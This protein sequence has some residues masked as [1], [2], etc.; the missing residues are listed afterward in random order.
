MPIKRRSDGKIIEE[1]TDPIRGR[2]RTGS[3]SDAQDQPTDRTDTLRERHADSL[4][5][6][7]RSAAN[8]GMEEPTVPMRTT[9]E[10]NKTRIVRPRQQSEPRVP[11]ADDPMLDPPAGWL[12]IVRGPGKGRALAIGNGMNVLGRG[13]RARVRIDFGDDTIARAN[14]ARVVYEPRQRLYLLSHGEG[15]NLTYLNGAVVTETVEIESGAMI[16][17]GE[18]TLRFQAFCGKEFDWSDLDA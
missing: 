10:E 1:R 7:G 6:S 9:R 14:H 2:E 3:A 5:G 11:A 18:T 8:P 12:V 13:P 4:F 17:V 15:S 16:E